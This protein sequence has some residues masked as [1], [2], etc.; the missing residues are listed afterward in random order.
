[1]NEVRTLLKCY[2][3]DTGINRRIQTSIFD[4]KSRH[5]KKPIAELLK[6]FQ[7]VGQRIQARD[8]SKTCAL[9]D[10]CIRKINAYDEACQLAERVE[11]QLK[12][13]IA[14]TEE[15]YQK[16]NDPIEITETRHTNASRT[17]GES[18]PTPNAIIADSVASNAMPVDHNSDFE[19]ENDVVTLDSSEP[20]VEFESAEEEI[21]SD[22]SF[23]WPKPGALKRKREKGNYQ[24]NVKKKKKPQIYKCID[25]P[26]DFRNKYE[27]QVISW[28]PVYFPREK[29]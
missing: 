5:S 29:K 7:K 6:R 28:I 13:M 11:K 2:I 12:E 15:R 26:A 8:G 27:M 24:E 22:D 19:Y 21:D 25:C 16:G 14:R 9:C 4:I 18:K 3:C 17:Q 1:M 23:Q 20:E 10:E